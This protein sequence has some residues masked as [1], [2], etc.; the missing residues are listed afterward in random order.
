MERFLTT[1]AAREVALG[2]L[3]DE[4]P[5]VRLH[6]AMAFGA[7]RMEQVEN[8]ARADGLPVEVRLR[9]LQHMVDFANPDRVMPLAAALFHHPDPQVLLALA[10]VAWRIEHEAIPA[11]L[12]RL[13]VDSAQHPELR[14][15]TI[16]ALAECGT[17]EQVEPLLLIVEARALAVD[18]KKAARTAIARIQG[19][20][21]GA[22]AG[23]LSVSPGGLQAG[24]LA[25]ARGA[26]TEP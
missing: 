22:R 19:R 23:Q 10:R 18:V 17:V 8:F 3:E 5:I 14:A 4:D 9:A 20:L 15:A 6:G 24:A 21:T 26:D 11:L 2:A 7:E 12:G 25:V 16:R 13:L 1:D